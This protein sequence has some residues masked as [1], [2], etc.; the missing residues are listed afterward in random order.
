MTINVD[1]YNDFDLALMC[2]AGYLGNGTER[3]TRLG[4][5]YLKV[6][7][8]V[9]QITRGTMPDPPQGG[10]TKDEVKSVLASM[11]PTQAEYDSFIQE[12]IKK[13]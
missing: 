1:K 10:I 7:L 5:R 3:R 9:N 12:V 13:L 11:R 4:P 8:I 6:Q 2:C